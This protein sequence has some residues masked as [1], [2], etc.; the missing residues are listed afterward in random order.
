MNLTYADF[1]FFLSAALLVSAMFG[2]GTTLTI[3]DFLDVARSPQG[4]LLV[5]AMQVLIT[6]LLAIALAK[7]FM[8][9][10]GIAIGLLLVAAMPGG[11]FSN[12]LTFLGRGN[13]ALSVK[14]AASEMSLGRVSAACINQEMGG[15]VVRRPSADRAEFFILVNNEQ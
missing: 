4:V 15:S 3:R 7:I 13:V 8:L 9:P 11:L 12:I 10:D 2:M 5:L 6:P 1:E 14:P